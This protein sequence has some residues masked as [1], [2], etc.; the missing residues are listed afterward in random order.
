[1]KKNPNR[2]QDVTSSADEAGLQG[3]DAAVFEAAD[4]SRAIDALLAVVRRDVDVNATR[5]TVFAS[6]DRLADASLL[7]ARVAPPAAGSRTTRRDMMRLVGATAAFAVVVPAESAFS[8]A[9]DF[10]RTGEE[11]SKN[12]RAAEETAKLEMREARA[13]EE[14]AKLAWR[15]A[16]E[17][18]KVERRD[19][20]EADRAVN[21][22]ERDLR[23]AEQ[24]QKRLGTQAAEE[25]AKR[26]EKAYQQAQRVA[27]QEKKQ[28]AVA[29][30]RA[31]EAKQKKQDQTRVSEETAKKTNVGEAARARRR[32]TYESEQA[33]KAEQAVKAMP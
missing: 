31:A 18:E 21:S 5:E 11:H 17:V 4:G 22:A 6:L 12:V 10:V 30:E 20:R 27:E 33:R 19:V 2:R 24:K 29:E 13:A 1:M 15:N 23:S 16:E 26:A 28:Y 8:K 7:E 3:I 32:N 9:A 25:D 14:K